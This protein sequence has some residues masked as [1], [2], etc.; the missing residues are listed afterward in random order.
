MLNKRSRRVDAKR[1]MFRTDKHATINVSILKYSTPC[2]NTCKFIDR[3]DMY[4]TQE[5]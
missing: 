4:I 5:T 3:N 2:E 1:K